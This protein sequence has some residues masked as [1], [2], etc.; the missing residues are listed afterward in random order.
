MARGTALEPVAASGGVAVQRRRGV[1][2]ALGRPGT[3][4]IIMT[5]FAIMLVACGGGSDSTGNKVPSISSGS[6][7]QMDKELA[8][9]FTFTLFQGEDKLGAGQLDLAAMRGKPL[10]LNFWAG[11]C[12]PCR[13]ELPDLQEYYNE[14]NDRATLVGIDLG[15]FTGLGSL[16]DAK[17]LLQEL[18]ITYP[19]GSTD[20]INV[21]KTYKILGMPTT[22][23]IDAKGELFKIWG[24]ALNLKVLRDQTLQMLGQ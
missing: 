17:D 20:D 3:L 16:Q 4:A 10:V 21:I 11:L 19:V 7:V 9:N 1:G 6:T 24:G 15:Q 14:F 13:A 12:P 22:V 2:P 18:N 8:P 23:F 5:V